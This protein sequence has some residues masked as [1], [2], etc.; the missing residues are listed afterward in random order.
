MDPN[1]DADLEMAAL[2]RTGSTMARLRKRGICLHGWRCSPVSG[3]AKC[4]DC[5]KVFPNAEALEEEARE[6]RIEY[7]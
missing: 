1:N 3:P 4:N 6:L 5:G 7:L 2:E